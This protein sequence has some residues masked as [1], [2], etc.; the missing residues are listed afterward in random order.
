MEGFLVSLESWSVAGYL[1][2]S[3]WGYA[4]VNTVHILGIALLVGS[5]VPLNLRLLGLW[6]GVPKSM[7][8]R[9]LVPVAI[10]GLCL[11]VIAGLLLFSVRAR[12]YAGMGFLQLKLVLVALGSLSA[13]FLHYRHGFTLDG[14]PVVRRIGHALLSLLCWTG[15]LAC[16][17][18]I[19]FSNS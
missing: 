15:A 8:A 9:V 12:E 18:L 16:G 10:T 4:A 1:R 14:I 3:R 6:Q 19:A 7:V 17:R 13:I 2:F 11:A 5:I